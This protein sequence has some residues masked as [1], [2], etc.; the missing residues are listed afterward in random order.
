MSEGERSL[1]CFCN[2]S[3]SSVRPP[4]HF[5]LVGR[6]PKLSLPGFEWD[7][8]SGLTFEAE[9]LEGIAVLRFI[10]V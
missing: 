2:E 8:K 6:S 1:D 5:G 4:S 3:L 9:D 10:R 7:G